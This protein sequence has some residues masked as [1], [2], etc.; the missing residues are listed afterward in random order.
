VRTRRLALPILIIDFLN[1]SA[2]APRRRACGRCGRRPSDVHGPGGGQRRPRAVT[3]PQ[4]TS[5]PTTRPIKFRDYDA[6]DNR[7]HARLKPVTIAALLLTLVLIFAFQGA[8]ILGRLSHIVLIAIP[9]VFEPPVGPRSRLRGEF[10]NPETR[11]RAEGYTPA[12]N[13]GAGAPQGQ[14]R[15]SVARS[16]RPG[17][18]PRIGD[19]SDRQPMSGDLVDVGR[20]G[21]WAPSLGRTGASRSAR[22]V[23]ASGDAPDPMPDAPSRSQTPYL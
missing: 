20:G 22:W 14:L 11:E 15:D 10:S 23:P 17:S 18:D 2:E 12:P 4:A 19:R 8:V 21:D 6:I 13:W 1:R 3:F 7:D 16:S 9:E 5:S